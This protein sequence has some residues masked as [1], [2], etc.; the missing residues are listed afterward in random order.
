MNSYG[1]IKKGYIVYF[2]MF[3]FVIKMKKNILLFLLLLSSFC[4]AKELNK[5]Y[6]LWY[7][8]PAFNRGGTFDPKMPSAYPYDEDWE[9][10]SLPIGNGYM[11][12]NIFGRI[13]TERI[14][15]SE[16][17]MANKGVYNQGGFTNFAE[18]YLDIYHSYS[19]DYKRELRLNDAVSIVQYQ[20]DSILYSREYFANYPSNIIVVKL[21]ADQSGRVSFKVRPVLPFLHPYNEEKT[22]RTGIVNAENDLITMQG[23]IQYFNLA[24]ECQIKVINYGGELKKTEDGCINVLKS[25]STVLLIAAGTSYQLT[26]SLFLLPPNKKCE[27]NEHPHNKIS[28]RINQA[29]QKGYDALLNEH[30][31]DYQN[32]FCRVDFCLDDKVPTIPTDKLLKN[33]QKGK[34]DSY[35][36]ELLFQYGRYLLI[37]SSRDGALPS[38]LQGGWNQYEYAPWSGGYWHNIN[39]QMN[40]WPVFNTN[41]AEL[42]VPYV[43]YN[44]AYRKAAMRSATNYVKKNNPEALDN[45]EGENG[46]TI[47]TAATAFGISG[48]GGHSGPGTGGFTTKLFWDYYDFTRDSEILEKHTYPAILGMAKFL[49]KTLKPSSDG[50]LLANPSSS[51]EQ[52]HKGVHYQ[53]IG[54]TFDQGMIWENYRDLLEASK[55]LKKKDAFIKVIEQQITKLDPIQIGES[56]QIKEYREEKKYGDIG[57]P[58]HRHVSHL[59][60]LYPGTLINGT[61]PEW[62]NAARISLDKRGDRPGIW[63]GWPMAFRFNHW[64]RIKDGDRA[65]NLYR[66]ILSEGVMENLWSLCPPF[67]IDA[68]FGS[69]AGVA[70]MLLQSHEGYIELLPALPAVWNNGFYRGLVARGNFEISATWKNGKATAFDVL[71]RKGEVC[72]IRYANIEQAKMT[73]AKGENVKYK[74]IGKDLI[75]FKTK[76]GDSFHIQL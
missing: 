65:Y 61:T 59:C 40:Y 38:N 15:L 26:D 46:W 10:W 14:Q 55:I 9:H 4:Q 76:L 49:S 67:Q 1:I 44:E 32:L 33:Y 47:G 16:K 60:P 58:I 53:T 12:A 17:T 8:H 19:K 42:F 63:K 25:D 71:S 51:P 24:Y 66:L 37:A 28:E 50:I 18:I 72:R 45:R 23:E 20:H 31:S 69:T 36:E 68:N 75:E 2:Y 34:R 74:I 54:C 52:R 57:D 3:K 70:E 11:G 35:L 39:V 73:D 43:K 5:I 41:L 7:D 22:G 30:I 56:G 6:S 64:A 27:G 13:D 29:V 21:K 48:P 62:L